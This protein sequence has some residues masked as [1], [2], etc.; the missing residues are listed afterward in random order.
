MISKKK[1]ALLLGAT[2]LIGRCLLECLIE[3]DEYERINIISRGPIDVNHKKITVVVKDFEQ[4]DTLTDWFN[5]DDVFCCLGTTSKK[6]LNKSSFR[7][8][9]YDYVVLSARLSKQR[10]VSKFLLVSAIGANSKSQFFYN[11][12]KGETETSIK[13]MYLTSVVIFRPSLLL[14]KRSEFRLGESIFAWLA[15]FYSVFL[16]GNLKK[17]RPINANSVS[18]AMIEYAKKDTGA[19]HVV[20]FD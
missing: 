10:N 1:T 9:D 18:K 6:S 19:Y 14:G 16:V 15:P 17:Y 2:G 12:L 4:L 20:Y 11:K 8:V 5:V 7:R 13:N 3:S